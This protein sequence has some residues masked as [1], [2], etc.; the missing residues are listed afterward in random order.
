MQVHREITQL[1]KKFLAI[2]HRA[3]DLP[4]HL[5][6]PASD[7][8]MDP[9]MEKELEQQRKEKLRLVEREMAWESEKHAIAL[10]K[11]QKR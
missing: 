2:Q 10:R 6:L 7:F 8:V 11:L 5:H 3:L 4:S 9:S 1:Q